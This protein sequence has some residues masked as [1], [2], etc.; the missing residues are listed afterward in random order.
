[1]KKSFFQRIKLPLFISLLVSLS[2]FSFSQEKPIDIWIQ[3][4]VNDMI[5]MNDLSKYSDREISSDVTINFF[6]V[7]SVKDI[8]IE[9]DTINMLISSDGQKYCNELKFRY[10]QKEQK[11]YLVFAPV[12]NRV[13]LNKEKKFITPWIEKKNLCE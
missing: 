5:E 2:F 7:E 13:I 11:Y 1:M 4:I 8:R 12:N 6:L 10:I 9:G 3:A